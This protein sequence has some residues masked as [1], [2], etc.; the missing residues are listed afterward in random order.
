M[1]YPLPAAGY[2]PPQRWRTLAVP[3][4]VVAVLLALAAPASAQVVVTAGDVLADPEAFNGQTITVE[5]ELV[6]D[7]GFRSDG[8][9]WT[10]LNSDSYIHAPVVEG[11]ELT[12]SNVGIGVRMPS[13]IGE[14]LDPPG[15]YR[16]RGPV[17]QAT[18]VWRYHDPT[19]GGE[20]Y[21]DAIDVVTVDP[22]IELEEGWTAWAAVSGVVLLVVSAL[23]WWRYRSAL[24]RR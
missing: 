23:I 19:R 6:G 4:A 16:V 15:G 3:V 5:G 10:Q 22:G 14:E 24:A 11:G 1:S 21:L 13:E 7:Y 20:S 9:M 17:V 8:T 12:G 2:E 18:G